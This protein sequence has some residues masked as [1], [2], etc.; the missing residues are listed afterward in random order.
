MY[1]AYITE[2]VVMICA[3]NI[4]STADLMCDFQEKQTLLFKIWVSSWVC[5]RDGACIAI[6]NRFV[7]MLQNNNTFAYFHKNRFWLYNM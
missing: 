4:P 3:Y 6:E 5:S 1:L 2:Y 7:K